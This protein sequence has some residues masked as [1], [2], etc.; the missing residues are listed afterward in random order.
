MD[1][2]VDEVHVNDLLECLVRS[3]IFSSFLGLSLLQEVRQVRLLSVLDFEI[4]LNHGF[5]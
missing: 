2:G 5:P 3:E 1:I 4:V